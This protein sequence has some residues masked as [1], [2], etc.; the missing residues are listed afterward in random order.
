MYLNRSRGVLRHILEMFM[1]IHL[2][3]GVESTLLRRILMVS[4]PAALVL[5]SPG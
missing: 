4:R 3:F 2:V 1:P 5:V